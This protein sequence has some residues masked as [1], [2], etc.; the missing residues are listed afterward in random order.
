MNDCLIKDLL[1][2]LKES[3]TAFHAAKELGNRLALSGFTP[4][5]L[6]DSW[7][8]KP[9]HSYFVENSGTVC[10]FSIP[11]RKIKSF[12]IFASHTDSPA[13]KLK[14]NPL[15]VKKQKIFLKVEVYGSPILTTWM[16][17]DLAIA[18]RS[19][20]ITPSGIEQ[21]LHYHDENQLIIPNLAVHL[22][23][24]NNDK[25]TINKELELCPLLT[26][27]T[28]KDPSK[29]LTKLLG[30]PIHTILSSDLFLVP[31]QEP[32]ILGLD[33]DLLASYRLDNLASCHC[34]L[35]A[36]TYP[37]ENLDSKALISL[38][39]NHEEV[40]SMSDEGAKSPF[41]LQ[42]MER[43]AFSQN[44]NPEDYHLAKNNST[45]TSVDM[46]H[47]Y[48][49]QY[50]QSY[51]PLNSPVM[52]KGVVLKHNANL[53]Y[54][55]SGKSGARII[56]KCR[57]KNIPSQFYAIESNQRCGSTI[58]PIISSTTGIPTVDIG[59]P[60]LSMHS[61]R[62]VI[63]IHDYQKLYKLLKSLLEG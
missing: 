17:K 40:G 47:A 26:A 37:R 35:A 7:A 8:L 14:P 49:P 50:S 53:S 1:A 6:N 41:F 56:Q 38:F 51:D 32:K 55:T 16:S 12:D 15:H 52:G 48:N 34:I 58:G 4:L 5:S 30:R 23:V 62:E 59:I 22:D 29:I 20:V 31:T 3:P 57:E 24:Q 28:T 54:S 46:A 45:V 10:A 44:M 33:S 39:Y 18:G 63:S 9:S 27:G 25:K 42:I 13:L 21:I 61:S 11:D 60:Q 36:L 43:I 19:F 2:F